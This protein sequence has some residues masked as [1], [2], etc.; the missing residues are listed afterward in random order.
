MPRHTISQIL[1]RHKDGDLEFDFFVLPII[2]SEQDQQ[3]TDNC[4]QIPEALHITTDTTNAFPFLE[5]SMELYGALAKAIDVSAAL[6]EYMGYSPS[7][8]AQ[9]ML[10]KNI[11]NT[12]I[13]LDDILEISSFYIARRKR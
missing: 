9:I 7:H 2:E 12:C 8:T 6:Y 5:G 10:A 1:I 13:L 11:S 3:P 4:P